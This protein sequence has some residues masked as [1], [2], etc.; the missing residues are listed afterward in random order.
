M[1]TVENNTVESQVNPPATSEQIEATAQASAEASNVQSEGNQEQESSAQQADAD[2]DKQLNPPVDPEPTPEEKYEAAKKKLKTAKDQDEID[3]I[4]KEVG[5]DEHPEFK[6]KLEEKKWGFLQKMKE[7]GIK[8]ALLGIPGWA[9]FAW[10]APLLSNFMGPDSFIMKALSA[11]GNFVK[12][13]RQNNFMKS[14]TKKLGDMKLPF[15]IDMEDVD[16]TDSLMT[17]KKYIKEKIKWVKWTS[18]ELVYLIT[19]KTKLDKSKINPQLV[20]MRNNLTNSEEISNGSDFIKALGNPKK[21]VKVQ[22]NTPSSNI[23]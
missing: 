9:A 22:E 19:G 17:A 4:I 15:D 21:L 16:F 18:E 14:F 7:A 13:M 1:T 6:K 12:N 23:G 5:L 3:K 2:L 10:L 11:V 8:T 20:A